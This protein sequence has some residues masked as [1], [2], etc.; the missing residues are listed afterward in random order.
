LQSFETYELAQNQRY[1]VM[2]YP[3]DNQPC[4]HLGAAINSGIIVARMTM[5]AQEKKASE[6][7]F[8][9]A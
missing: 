5:G 7:A 1:P 6:Q 4:L 3:G 8:S 2:K 9:V